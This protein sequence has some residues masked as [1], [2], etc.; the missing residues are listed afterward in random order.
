[1]AAKQL[2]AFLGQ[3]AGA[4]NPA[5]IGGII[6]RKSGIVCKSGFRRKLLR[7]SLLTIAMAKRN[8][9]WPPEV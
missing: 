4:E 9:N 1:M 6:V 5:G 3:I 2:G 8:G 7:P